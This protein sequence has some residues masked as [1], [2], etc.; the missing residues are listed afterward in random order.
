M[1]SS[2]DSPTSFDEEETREETRETVRG[3]NLEI[4]TERIV[5]DEV[6][7]RLRARDPTRCAWEVSREVVSSEIDAF[8]RG[9]DGGEEKGGKRERDA[10]GGGETVGT[11]PT[12]A[13]M[14]KQRREGEESGE[15]VVTR[16]RRALE[17]QLSVT[18]QCYPSH[19]L[20]F[21]AQNKGGLYSRRLC[22]ANDPCCVSSA[23]SRWVWSWAWSQKWLPIR[24]C[25]QLGSLTPHLSSIQVRRA[26]AKKN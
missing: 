20:F 26:F 16:V 22:Q 3:M 13:R 7:R 2:S 17:G 24:R 21:S 14:K 25:L 1:T 19:E 18:S 11:S 15:D 5:R 6:A 23:A 10:G 12:L 9:L 8:L 4:V